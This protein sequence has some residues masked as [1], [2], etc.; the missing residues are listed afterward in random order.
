MSPKLKNKAKQPK[1]NLEICSKKGLRTIEFIPTMGKKLMD[2][3]PHLS[4]NPSTTP[5]N[6]IFAPM[7]GDATA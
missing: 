3:N 1:N 7:A 6:P 5:E 4:P 2:F